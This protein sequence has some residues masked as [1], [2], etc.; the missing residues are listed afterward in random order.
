MFVKLMTSKGALHG[1][2]P[3]VFGALARCAVDLTSS[4][5][6]FWKLRVAQGDL[7]RR[8]EG[9]FQIRLHN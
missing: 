9:E 6:P 4:R 1:R 3:M 8:A 7:A 5:S 2:Q